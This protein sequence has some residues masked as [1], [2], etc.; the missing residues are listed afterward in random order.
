VLAW[1]TLG[2]LLLDRGWSGHQG[3][4]WEERESD[5]GRWSWVEVNEGKLEVKD[6]RKTF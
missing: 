4:T 1:Y 6:E 3:N 2:E 5:H